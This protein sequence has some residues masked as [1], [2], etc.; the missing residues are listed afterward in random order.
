MVDA[1]ELAATDAPGV[2]VSWT[3]RHF[4]PCMLPSPLGGLVL[5]T[6]GRWTYDTSTGVL[7]DPEGAMSTPA[8]LVTPL[9]RVLSVDA[10]AIEIAATLRVVGV[11]PLIVASWS[12]ISIDGE[13]D[14]SSNVSGP[15]AGANPS[16]CATHAP[17]DG[18]Q[19]NSGGSG[20]GGGGY[21]G[22]GG[23]GGAGENI[24][25]ANGGTAVAVP[26]LAGGCRGGRGGHGDASG[27]EGAG[28]AGGGAIQL[29]ARDSITIA[30]VV[31]VG[32]SGG[33]GGDLDSG[34][35]GG[36]SGG[37][38][39]LEAPMIMIA[40]T[41]VLA[42]NGGG[43]GGG[44]DLGNLGGR[45]SDA[46]PNAAR[47]TGGAGG[48]NGDGGPGGDAS[49]GANLGG[50]GGGASALHAGGGGGGGAGYVVIASPNAT[51]A[52]PTVSPPHITP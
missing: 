8:S 39:G 38:I 35:G 15:G 31:H 47:A 43:G 14:A 34:G 6:P 40:A 32:G 25:G 21:S 33:G 46:T 24:A 50:L 48:D 7:V 28:G 2:C 49:A 30:G 5:A 16:S 37:M 13:L 26:L 27:G 51:V 18:R 3:A 11:R 36:G 45:G 42:A 17:Q 22:S 19:D 20:G 9:G 1:P 44:A 10:L 29:T 52:T 4:Q 41:A 23:S 12:T